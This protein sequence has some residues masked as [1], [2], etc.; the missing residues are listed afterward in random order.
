M[1]FAAAACAFLLLVARPA[2]AQLQ[3]QVVV[4][5]LQSPVAF[6]QDPTDRSVQGVVQQAGQI[7]VVR[8]GA[9][10]GNDF[11]NLTSSVSCCGEQGLLGLAFAPDYASSGRFYVN[12]TNSAGNTVVARFLR[13][14][15]SS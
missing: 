10:A 14:S 8:D 11:L 2:H 3:S 13:S 6:V 9:I 4:T 7:R 15:V 12:F 5:G 1:R